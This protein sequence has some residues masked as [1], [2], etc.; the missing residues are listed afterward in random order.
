MAGLRNYS[1]TFGEL[2][3]MPT[4][5]QGDGDGDGVMGGGVRGG[6]M[7]DPLG[8]GNMSGFE[9]SSFMLGE[10]ATY[11]F[12]STYP[13]ATAMHAAQQQQAIVASAVEIVVRELQPH[14]ARMRGEISERLMNALTEKM[15]NLFDEFRQEMSKVVE[16][17]RSEKKGEDDSD[18]ERDRPLTQM[19]HFYTRQLLGCA[20]KTEK[21]P[22]GRPYYKLPPPLADGEEPRLAA[23]GTQLWNPNWFADVDVGINAEFVHAVVELVLENGPK[24]FHL[25]TDQVPRTR[26]EEYAKTYFRTLRSQY[27]RRATAEGQKKIGDKSLREKVRQ[28]KKR[29]AA[30]M[31]AAIPAFRKYYHSDKTEGIDALVLTEWQSSEHDDFGA[32]SEAEWKKCRDDA[33]VGQSAVEL[34]RIYAVLRK[35]ADELH[36]GAQGVRYGRF[37]GPVVNYNLDVPYIKRVRADKKGMKKERMRPTQECMSESWA[38]HTDNMHLLE[39]APLAPESMTIFGLTILDDDLPK[40]DCGWIAD[41]EDWEE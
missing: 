18:D 15:G 34:N 30:R 22:T 27:Q 21:G 10:A 37:R 35:F 29:K 7:G 25:D 23:D 38:K 41:V 26:I 1:H 3:A 24:V 6:G 13:G 36:S 16:E 32:A 11:N 31:R 33:M 9:P 2:N 5:S 20:T 28:Q 12:Q 17:V 40:D 39:G 19:V 4:F 8:L 14:L